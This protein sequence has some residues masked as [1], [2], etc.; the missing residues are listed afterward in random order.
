MK[1]IKGYSGY[2]ILKR[3]MAGSMNIRFIAQKVVS[4]EQ[5]IMLS[6]HGCLPY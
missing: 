3:E 2:C 5:I 6:W 1:L 4:G